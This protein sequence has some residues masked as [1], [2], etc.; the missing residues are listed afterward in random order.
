MEPLER[1]AVMADH[2]KGLLEVAEDVL[3]TWRVLATGWDVSRK[4]PN[5]G[6]SAEATLLMAAELWD[7][8]LL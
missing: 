4:I 3:G 6:A 2:S 1:I 7:E 8:D 5:M